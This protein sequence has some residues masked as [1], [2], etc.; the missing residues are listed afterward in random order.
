MMRLPIASHE[1]ARGAPSW[2]SAR[3]ESI[4]PT[5]VSPRGSQ[6]LE[7]GRDISKR[8]TFDHMSDVDLLSNVS[9]LVGSHRAVTA[10]LAAYLAELDER[11]LHLKAG[12]ASM[13]EFCVKELGMSE[14]ET[15]RRLLAAR[16]GKRFPIV[17]SLLARGEVHLSAL[18]LVREHLTDENHMELLEAVSG[19]TKAEIRA[20][21]AARFPRP[22]VPTSIRQIL[23]PPTTEA[24][25]S[26]STLPALVANS[27]N[28]LATDRERTHVD[29]LSGDRF[30]VEFTA[31]AT[32]REKLEFCRDLLSH[33]NPGR[34]LALVVERA[35]DLLLADLQRKRLGHVNRVRVGSRRRHSKPGSIAKA[36]R[37]EVF[38]RDGT[39]CT[40]VSANGRRCEARAFLEL[41]HITPKALGGRDEVE[42]LRVRC[43]AHNQLSAEEAFGRSHIERR[44]HLR[45]QKCKRRRNRD[46]SADATVRPSHPA[47]AK[48]LEKVRLA[49]SGMGF[50]DQ[51]AR[52]ATDRV[53][54]M[55]GDADF[56]CV[57]QALREALAVLTQGRT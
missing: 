21:L 54:A 22:D 32:L 34:D 29:P 14:G 36:V 3:R 31:S 17:Y 27:A 12:F 1:W 18:E 53:G 51:E 10:K 20:L 7:N 50:R 48:A 52:H 45:Q 24:A 35:V 19:K 11:R 13:F 46:E 44:V 5:I 38:E 41:D 8:M 42:N 16:L 56:P 4:E 40:Y 15:F 37:R 47:S 2:P 43:R 33:A 49:L 28:R 39:R 25:T 57:E 23:V 6:G 9:K 55:H 30:R 26:A